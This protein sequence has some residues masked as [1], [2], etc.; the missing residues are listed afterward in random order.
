MGCLEPNK[1]I[2]KEAK[3]IL[4]NFGNRSMKRE[5]IAQAAGFA[6]PLVARKLRELADKKL[7][8]EEEGVYYLSDKGKEALDILED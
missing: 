3:K 8:I 2:S 5:E 4:R 1:N 6:L 7:V